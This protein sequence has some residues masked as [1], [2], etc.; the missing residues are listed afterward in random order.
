MEV[1]ADT[2]WSGRSFRH[3]LGVIRPRPELFPTDIILPEG[4]R[5]SEQ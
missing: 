2:A 5:L 4:M 1:T 3:A